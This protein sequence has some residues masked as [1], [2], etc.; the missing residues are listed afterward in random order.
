M[1]Y[2]CKPDFYS[3]H[4]RHNTDADMLFKEHSL[5]NADQLYGISAECGLKTLMSKW[6]MPHDENGN[7]R[8]KDRLH[9]DQIWER[10]ET[11]RAGKISSDYGLSSGNPFSDWDVSQ[12]YEDDAKITINVVQEHKNAAKEVCSLVQK[13]TLDGIL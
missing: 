13:A 5:A 8:K 7:P 4:K 9:I 2:C 11:Y 1:E 10:Y 12:R 6:G 3:A